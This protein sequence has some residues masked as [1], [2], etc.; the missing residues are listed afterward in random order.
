MHKT[1]E[2]EKFSFKRIFEIKQK[3]DYS[4]EIFLYT[5][6]QSIIKHVNEYLYK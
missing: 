4:Y 6:L 3:I 2:W 1:N 5:K